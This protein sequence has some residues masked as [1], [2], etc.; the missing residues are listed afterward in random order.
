MAS[1]T[2]KSKQKNKTDLLFNYIRV[3]NLIFCFSVVTTMDSE[4]K[5]K[6]S[7]K[8]KRREEKKLAKAERKNESSES[9]QDSDSEYDMPPKKRQKSS[10]H[11]KK[12]KDFDYE[13]E[14]SSEIKKESESS[15]SHN[16][17]KKK[18]KRRKKSEMES[19]VPYSL[20]KT[21]NSNENKIG[22]IM[23][24][25][26]SVVYECKQNEEKNISK[27]MQRFKQAQEKQEQPKIIQEIEDFNKKFGATPNNI[28]DETS[29]EE[30]DKV[31]E[32]TISNVELFEPGTSDK[33]HCDT[34]LG[35]CEC[36]QNSS[37]LSEKLK[38]EGKRIVEIKTPGTI[39][40]DINKH[41]TPTE[42]TKTNN[43]PSGKISKFTLQ[44][45]AQKKT[46]KSISTDNRGASSSSSSHTIAKEPPMVVFEGSSNQ[47]VYEV[48]NLGIQSLYDFLLQHGQNLTMG[49]GNPNSSVSTA[50]SGFGAH[51]DINNPRVAVSSLH[52][53]DPNNFDSNSETNSS[54]HTFKASDGMVLGMQ[55]QKYRQAYLEWVTNLKNR[56]DELY[57]A[58]SLDPNKKSD[59][60][61]IDVQHVSFMLVE[62][63]HPFK[64]CIAGN[65]CTM[66]QLSADSSKTFV[67]MSYLSK[68]EFE[69][70]LQIGPAAIPKQ[71]TFCYLCLLSIYNYLVERNKCEGHSCK[72]IDFPFKHKISAVGGYRKSAMIVNSTGYTDGVNVPFRQFDYSDY[73]PTTVLIAIKINNGPDEEKNFVKQKARAFREKSELL[74]LKGS[75]NLEI[76]SVNPYFDVY[77]DIEEQFTTEFLLRQMFSVPLNACAYISRVVALCSNEAARK[78]ADGIIRNLFGVETNIKTRRRRGYL[79]VEKTC[80][81]TADSVEESLEWISPDKALRPAVPG[82]FDEDGN[83]LVFDSKKEHSKFFITTN[84]I[85]AKH[86]FDEMAVRDNYLRLVYNND[87]SSY[88]SPDPKQESI[89]QYFERFIFHPPP[90]VVE[91]DRNLFTSVTIKNKNLLDDLDYSERL[92]NL[93]KQPGFVP[94]KQN[95][96]QETV[97]QEINY[98]FHRHLEDKFGAN[99]MNLVFS[100]NIETTAS[101]IYHLLALFGFLIRIQVPKKSAVYKGKTKH[102][103]NAQFNDIGVL[104]E[105]NPTSHIEKNDYTSAFFANHNY[106]SEY[107]GNFVNVVH[108]PTFKLHENSVL[109]ESDIFE[110]RLYHA[111]HLRINI[112][113]M[114]IDICF[115]NRQLNKNDFEDILSRKLLLFI[116]GHYEMITFYAHTMTIPQSK[117]VSE[118]NS[119]LPELDTLDIYNTLHNENA[120]D[121]E[122]TQHVELIP[123]DL[124]MEQIPKGSNV[125]I[126]NAWGQPYELPQWKCWREILKPKV[127]MYLEPEDLVEFKFKTRKVFRDPPRKEIRRII[128][129]NKEIMEKIPRFKLITE[130]ISKKI[131][132][133]EFKDSCV[134]LKQKWTKKGTQFKE[135][136]LRATDGFAHWSINPTLYEP[137]NNAFPK[138]STSQEI[139]L[140]PEN[141]IVITM[142]L[143]V[144]IG[145]LLASDIRDYLN[146]NSNDELQ[147]SLHELA[148]LLRLY[149]QTHLELAL[150]V[151]D[152]STI[153][154]TSIMNEKYF[155]DLQL[156]PFVIY[157]PFDAGFFHEGDLDATAKYYSYINFIAYNGT[158]N[159]PWFYLASKV[160]PRCCHRRKFDEKQDIAC[161]ESP[162]YYKWWLTCVYVSMVGNYRHC[163]YWPS[164]QRTLQMYKFLLKHH[165]TEVQ[166]KFMNMQ[167]NYSFMISE[168]M[169]EH[170]IFQLQFNACYK[171]CIEEA[172]DEWT[173]F[174]RCVKQ[175]MDVARA[176]YDIT[177]STSD[178]DER[179]RTALG[180]NI[181]VYRCPNTSFVE[182]ILN[183]IKD[184]FQDVTKFEK[185]RKS[186]LSTKKQKNPKG[187]KKKAS[188]SQNPTSKNDSSGKQ[189]QDKDFYNNINYQAP[190]EQWEMQRMLNVNMINSVQALSK[191]EQYNIRKYV[192]TLEPLSNIDIESFSYLGMSQNGISV[193][194][195]CYLLYVT[196]EN[197]RSVLT[198]LGSMKPH[199]FE[200]L[201][202]IMRTIKTHYSLR[203]LEAPRS[204]ALRQEQSVRKKYNIP[205]NMPLPKSTYSFGLAECCSV[206]KT[207]NA[208]KHGTKF[209]GH[210]R[211]ILQG[212][213]HEYYCSARPAKKTSSKKKALKQK[214]DKQQ[215]LSNM[216]IDPNGEN[217]FLLE[218]MDYDDEDE[219]ENNERSKLS[220]T[221]MAENLHNN[222]NWA[223]TIPPVIWNTHSFLEDDPNNPKRSDLSSKGGSVSRKKLLSNYRN[224]CQ[225]TKIIAVP[226]LGYFV[227]FDD[228][229]EKAD[230]KT[231]TLC[232]LCGSA[233]LF[234]TSMYHINGFSC[235]V[236]NRQELEAFKQPVCGGCKAIKKTNRSSWETFTMFDDNADNGFYKI[237]QFDF[238]RNCTGRTFKKGFNS[239]T[240]SESKILIT[241]QI[242][243]STNEYQAE[244]ELWNRWTPETIC[245][246][247][248]GNKTKQKKFKVKKTNSSD[249]QDEIMTIANEDEDSWE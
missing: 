93:Q 183:R 83:N 43:K 89:D 51:N 44:L 48:N 115:Q 103:I 195:E 229:K 216:Q 217:T 184:Y 198:L 33:Q 235:G 12:E 34:C 30:I 209:Y 92:S 168:I 210:Q 176:I 127:Q 215:I 55:S 35:V 238:C 151:A 206:I 169:R 27:T 21:K 221:E 204:L 162:N 45:E 61:E 109:G 224:V 6:G 174:E 218:G 1:A 207:P 16:Q 68:Q 212:N 178:V 112:S 36:P 3:L 98:M 37:I 74:F 181:D 159:Q 225:N 71:R 244:C 220:I 29:S 193:V 82:D 233:T 52:K 189:E 232:P 26:S 200:L 130:L 208:Q 62:P 106:D 142:M 54:G 32:E 25:M 23:K 177:G 40:S 149:S 77:I 226:A 60:Q 166:A 197:K 88:F 59:P 245:S 131:L 140:V 163:K 152:T 219:D 125:V 161:T 111:L 188:N 66:L 144:N 240:I 175:E 58:D 80:E 100:E 14:T 182:F 24:L 179:M 228:T 91:Y 104:D 173:N 94:Q 211:C 116:E 185:S 165:T 31:L 190:Y 76:P 180:N 227:E 124:Q 47:H 167:I 8:R 86:I 113:Q 202:F 150:F 70:Y 19:S 102:S 99:P 15:S 56:F 75:S 85:R 67:G 101:H 114:L 248:I 164:F 170:F 214:K 79:F 69:A 90:N 237:S 105:P 10:H 128:R 110:R 145:M 148:Y 231:M 139:I 222:E 96:F 64:P 73:V 9:E 236:C 133:K 108:Y 107:Y 136:L 18:R 154:D 28:I 53:I 194:W 39:L 117:I 230:P 119:Q 158:Q 203:I 187:E 11:K 72:K 120:I 196:E 65:N 201:W 50:T 153:S 186:R 241:K 172:F 95:Q 199:D 242:E 122:S 7:K 4:I 246:E 239:M 2:Y 171:E 141:S 137:S 78:R 20:F 147:K 17:E 138:K 81:S 63:V 134:Y 192:A 41:N 84:W 42:Q 135:S 49:T 143:R 247:P 223:D 22:E 146:K 97:I 243:I 213:N 121:P 191:E 234:S 13:E 123:T 132:W 205:A 57:K 5:K 129:Q 249:F 118:H 87:Y 157:Y 46:Q 156:S 155:K 160:A 38:K 126:P